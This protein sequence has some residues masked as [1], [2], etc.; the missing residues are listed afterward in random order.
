M[1]KLKAFTL[2]EVLIASTIFSVVAMAA[3]QLYANTSISQQRIDL[4]REMMEETRFTLERI[5]SEVR[6]G[7]IDYSEYWNWSQTEACEGDL[8]GDGDVS[9]TDEGTIPNDTYEMGQSYAETYGNCYQFYAASFYQPDSE[10]LFRFFKNVNGERIALEHR[11]KNNADAIDVSVQSWQDELYLINAQGTKKTILRRRAS[12]NTTV[13]G[14]S[15][16]NWSCDIPDRFDQDETASMDDYCRLEILRL[17][18]KDIDTDGKI[19]TWECNEEFLGD[20]S[21]LAPGA[22]DGCRFYPISPPNLHVKDLKFF[23]TPTDDPY[24]AYNEDLNFSLQPHVT[25]SISTET[26]KR[27]AAFLPG[28]PPDIQIQTTV[29]ARVFNEVTLFN[30]Y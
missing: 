14:D 23:I 26:S 21:G 22:P 17:D 20:N 8:N 15:D 30:N 11:G 3:V 16:A 4:T 19:D 2:I 29:A 24:K 13:A 12:D 27:R 10:G 6:L 25:I 7:T 18:G 9:S 1:K 5:V 28:E